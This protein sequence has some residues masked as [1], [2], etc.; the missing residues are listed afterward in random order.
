MTV[1][2]LQ[3]TMCCPYPG[4]L[5]WCDVLACVSL[6]AHSPPTHTHTKLLSDIFPVILKGSCF[7]TQSTAALS[8]SLWICKLI[9][10]RTSLNPASRLSLLCLA[11]SAPLHSL[12]KTYEINFRP[13]WIAMTSPTR[14]LCLCIVGFRSGGK[15][16]YLTSCLPDH[17][18]WPLGRAEMRGRGSTKLQSH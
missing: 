7:N 9:H 18:P 17:C 16:M 8:S 15:D 2:P 12:V 10:A 13:R 11:R 6:S 14:I 3:T 4:Q 1:K 5:L